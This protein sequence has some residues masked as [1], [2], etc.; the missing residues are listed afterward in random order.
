LTE[1]GFLVETAPD[2]TDAVSMVSQSEEYYY[3]AILMDVQMPIMDGY[4]AT[5][6]IRNMARKDVKTLPIIAMTANALEE[7][8]EAA[9]K[10]GMNA[11]IAKPLDMD[12]FISVLHQFL[13]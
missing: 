6:T 4:E 11:H 13:D 3:D 5:R 10:N 9:I 2:G 1:S 8:K 12:I 7:D